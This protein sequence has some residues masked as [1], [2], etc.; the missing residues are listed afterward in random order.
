VHVHR[1]APYGG[2]AAAFDPLPNI[3]VGSSILKEYLHRAGGSVEGA[4]KSYVGAALLPND[5]GY[6]Q[7][8][9]TARERIAA[10]AA[11]DS[12]SAGVPP[13]TTAPGRALE[14][15]TRAEPDRIA[16]SGSSEI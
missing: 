15:T 1:F 5:R 14:R 6:G 10:A 2:T 13:V 3:L 9:L 11:A 8:V 7:K 12:A 16:R 4:L